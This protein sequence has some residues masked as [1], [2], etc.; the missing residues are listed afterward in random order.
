[1]CQISF[2]H[3]CAHETFKPKQRGDR[4][5]YS[6]RNTGSAFENVRDSLSS[7]RRPRRYRRIRPGLLHVSLYREGLLDIWM[8]LVSAVCAGHYDP[9]DFPPTNQW[10]STRTPSAHRV[11]SVSFSDLLRCA[12][13]SPLSTLRRCRTATVKPSCRN[14]ADS[15]K[16][17]PSVFSCGNQ[18]RSDCNTF[19]SG[20]TCTG[21]TGCAW[22][23][24]SPMAVNAELHC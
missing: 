11:S 13:K 6:R 21:A 16:L 19:K 3:F 8:Q 1:M 23:L 4:V 7:N 22:C 10:F 17:P 5:A 9:Q 20:P 24:V 15:Q 14:W 12:F 2:A 18:T